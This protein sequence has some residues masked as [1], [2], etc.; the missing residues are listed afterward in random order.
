MHQVRSV[1]SVSSTVFGI[2]KQDWS[3]DDSRGLREV[4]SLNLI[5]LLSDEQL[6]HTKQMG[7]ICHDLW[8]PYNVESKDN[9]FP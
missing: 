9:K 7:K 5:F 1:G 3:L 2:S 8:Q 4:T 6:R